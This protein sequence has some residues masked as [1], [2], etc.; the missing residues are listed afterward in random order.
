MDEPQNERKQ[1]SGWRA[2]AK[3][4]ENQPP[5]SRFELLQQQ[6]SMFRIGP[7]PVGGLFLLVVLFVFPLVLV[8]HALDLLE[9]WQL[10]ALL[11]IVV[12]VFWSYHRNQQQ[13]KSEE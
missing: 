6:I 4:L 8:W 5:P 12:V 3:R 13:E 1:D 7:I 9:Y 11:I 10:K 2:S